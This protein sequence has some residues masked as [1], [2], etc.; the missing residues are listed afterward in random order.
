MSK[1]SKNEKYQQNAEKKAERLGYQNKKDTEYEAKLL[2]KEHERKIAHDKKVQSIKDNEMK[3]KAKEDA[4]L[5]KLK[6]K[7]VNYSIRHTRKLENIKDTQRKR[8]IKA[9]EILEKN[10]K[11][12][13]QNKSAK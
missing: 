9:A 13:E 6:E 4:K 11:W 3:R 2:K 10:S 8:D 1:I 5:A 7:D 12:Q